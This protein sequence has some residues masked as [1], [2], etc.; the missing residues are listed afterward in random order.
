MKFMDENFLLDTEMAKTLYHGFAEWRM[1]LVVK[2]F[3]FILPAAFLSAFL[4]G[5]VLLFL[6]VLFPTFL[7]VFLFH[8]IPPLSTGKIDR[9]MARPSNHKH[10]S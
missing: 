2:V 7:L 6:F 3:V 8:P 5:F 4:P 10:L 9:T 1:I